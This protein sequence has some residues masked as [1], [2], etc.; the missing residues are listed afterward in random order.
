MKIPIAK[1]FMGEEEAQASYDVVKSGWITQGPK[2]AEF[3]KLYAEKVNAKYAVAVS[4][5]TTALHLSLLDAGI[6]EGD[7][8]ICP[9]M[10]F[11]A[12]A[13]A[14]RYCGAKP[15]F[16]DVNEEYNLDPTA[17]E[18]K[19]TD[20]TKAILLVHQIGMPANIDAFQ[21]IVAK[22]NLILIEDAACAIGSKFNDA[23]IGSH[24]KYVCFSLHPRKV[25]STGEGGMIATN[26]ESVYERL[27]L[28]R[29]HGMS[30]NDQVRHNATTVI[31]ESYEILGYNYRMTDIQASI[32]IE[33][34]KKLDFIIGKRRAIAKKYIDAFSS[35]QG[36]KLPKEEKGYFSNYQSFSILLTSEVKI[37]RDDIMAKL[38]DKGIASRRGIML[39]HKELPYA[40]YS[41][42]PVTERIS[43]NSILLPLFVQ[44]TN[45]EI[46]YVIT[47]FSKL[48]YRVLPI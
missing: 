30:V 17:V 14:I 43:D 42:M 31:I 1:P 25:I 13:N 28:L 22:H 2:V 23:P 29:Q 9:S 36:L 27:K 47:E 3:E 5:C 24:T 18:S 4:N 39:S 32:G 35:I 7:E 40:S 45:E 48:F 15:I 12:T 34:L 16:A 21:D 11:I 44:M 20:K 38:L 33:Q 41:E 10:S 37:S 6:K 26:S 8:V 19:I 46:E